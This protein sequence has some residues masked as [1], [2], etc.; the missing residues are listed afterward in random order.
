MALLLLLLSA[1]LLLLLPPS[2]SEK[3]LVNFAINEESPPGHT[4]GNVAKAAKLDRSYTAMQFRKL[5]FSLL[6]GDSSYFTL[7]RHTGRLQVSSR[8]DRDTL[9]ER[10]NYKWCCSRQPTECF[11]PL[12]V[13][14]TPQ[15]FFQLISVRVYIWDIN[16]HKPTWSKREYRVEVSEDAD[17]GDTFGVPAPSD[18]DSGYNA[19]QRYRLEDSS[20]TFTL[21]KSGLG[22]RNE[23]SINGEVRIRLNRQLD[24]ESV[25]LYNLTLYAMDGGH[26]PQ[27]G[28]VSI[29]VRITDVN[30]HAP[31][32]SKSLYEEMVSE[33]AQI[34]H[35]ILRVV[36]K[37]E[38]E[39]NNAR[40]TYSFPNTVSR[41]VRRHFKLDPTN[42]EITLLSPLDYE[43][44]REYDFTVM[45][46]DGNENPRS[47]ST[48]VRILVK[49]SERSNFTYL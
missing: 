42:G 33:S 7:H 5:Q 13:S 28:S 37:D 40:I 29:Q 14:V 48:R 3:V 8:I 41:Q 30:D 26:R 19:T 44:R 38:D 45:A 18:A 25:A 21:D 4:V 36:A 43:A 1:S 15:E 23:P 35:F 20:R 12:Q 47:A 32:F 22:I 24:R 16:D 17:V 10:S 31:H 11:I 27:T 49:V 46:R 9:C 2:L 34:H 6:D 39:G